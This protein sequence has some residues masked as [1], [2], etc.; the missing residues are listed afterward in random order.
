MYSSSSIYVWR[1]I[2]SQSDD[3]QSP[4]DDVFD[5]SQKEYASDSFSASN[6]PAQGRRI[7]IDFNRVS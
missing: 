6:T 4:T 1:Y 2:Q 3:I 5:S 7:C